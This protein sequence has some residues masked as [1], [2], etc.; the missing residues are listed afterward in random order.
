[1]MFTAGLGIGLLLAIG[2]YHFVGPPPIVSIVLFSVGTVGV[3][4][5]LVFS[6][7]K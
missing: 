7:I 6:E 5:K 4:I 2:L 1:M 3:I